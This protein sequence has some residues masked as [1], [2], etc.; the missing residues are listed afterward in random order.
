MGDL[1]LGILGKNHGGSGLISA[2]CR[3]TRHDADVMG[4]MGGRA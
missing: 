2:G 1:V 4:F 3:E